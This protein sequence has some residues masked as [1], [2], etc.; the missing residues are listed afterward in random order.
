MWPA[1]ALKEPRWLR[2]QEFPTAKADKGWFRKVQDK[3]LLKTW[4]LHVQKNHECALKHY[5][6]TVLRIMR[7]T[8]LVGSNF[9][10]L[11]FLVCQS[12]GLDGFDVWPAISEGKDSPR[13][14]ILHN[15]DPLHRPV[16]QPAAWDKVKKGKTSDAKSWATRSERVDLTSFGGLM[17]QA[18][19]LKS[20][21]PTS[22]RRRK[23]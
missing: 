23:W 15:I 17:F 9:P 4:H 11:Y 1:Q 12:R 18:P 6:I 16:F 5:T 3:T 22:Q 14:E 7:K 20:R 10:I 13:H 21:P 8:D 2:I 19:N